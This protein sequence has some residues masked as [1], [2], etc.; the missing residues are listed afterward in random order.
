MSR[1]NQAALAQGSN[2]AP[3]L[4]IHGFV[5][6]KTDD[7]QALNLLVAASEYATAAMR[8]L[9][10]DG[11]G[12]PSASPHLIDR[13]I[14]TV[15]GLEVHFVFPNLSQ[16]ERDLL[17][18]IM[19]VR[20]SISAVL[21]GA[22][23]LGLAGEKA[24]V[25]EL[26]ADLNSKF[27]EFRSQIVES[28]IEQQLDPLQKK[29]FQDEFFS[30]TLDKKCSTTLFF[31]SDAAPGAAAGAVQGRE[32]A[33]KSYPTSRQ[34]MR[35]S[36]SPAELGSDRVAFHLPEM[37][38]QLS[39]VTSCKAE[40]RIPGRKTVLLISSDPGARDVVGRALRPGYNLLLAGA[41]FTGYATA[42][43]ERPDLVLV[44][45]N[46]ST[47]ASGPNACLDGRGV[48]KMLASLPAD[49][50]LPFV[51]LAPDGAAE[52]GAPVLASGAKASLQKPLDPRAVIEAVQN[53][54]ASLGLESNEAAGRPWAVSASV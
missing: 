45:L 48:L 39:D 43:R 6:K 9:I 4:G 46:L 42:M 3:R 52:T 47:E 26:T 23:R 17:V 24:G 44:D 50:A 21:N 29:V 31:R 28:G 12:T 22:S 8:R 5:S 1:S 15:F 53:A 10:P 27:L 49:R 38:P 51:A 33:G 11:A 37:A 2:G 54:E 16:A 41:G 35:A 13:Y 19:K 34:T 40:R 36:G 14:D 18:S 20:N 30:I 7:P 32:G 25:D